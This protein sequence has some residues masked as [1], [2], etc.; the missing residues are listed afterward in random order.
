M[1]SRGGTSGYSSTHALPAGSPDIHLPQADAADRLASEWLDHHER[2]GA[3]AREA[4]IRTADDIRRVAAL[5]ERAHNERDERGYL[6]AGRRAVATSQLTAFAPDLSPRRTAYVAAATVASA[7]TAAAAAAATAEVGRS[8]SP[9]ARRASVLAASA[10]L[11]SSELVLGAASAREVRAELGHGLPAHLG[12]LRLRYDTLCAELESSTVGG[13]LTREGAWGGLVD[14][15][16]QPSG[17]QHASHSSADGR[18]WRQQLS[19]GRRVDAVGLRPAAAP[20][21]A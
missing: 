17:K 21:A 7:A 4:V 11:A 10:R 12:Q 9:G 14:A 6:A 3:R 2:V 18:E 13:S 8:R 20:H 5:A 16:A 1:G 15:A 19:D